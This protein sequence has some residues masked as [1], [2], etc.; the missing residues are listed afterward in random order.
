M[1]DFVLAFV[2][3]RMFITDNVAGCYFNNLKRQ[4]GPG[5]KLIYSANS[6]SSRS[7]LFH[8]DNP[9]IFLNSYPFVRLFRTKNFTA[10]ELCCGGI[11][12]LLAF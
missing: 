3:A 10:K 11:A 6:I 7:L 9:C 4:S 8:I 2:F 5:C 12:C 1:N